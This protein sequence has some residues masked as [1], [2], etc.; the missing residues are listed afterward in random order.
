MDNNE[1]IKKIQLL[2]FNYNRHAFKIDNFIKINIFHHKEYE[3]MKNL[4]NVYDYKN[5][6]NKP[7]IYKNDI[8][9]C[10]LIFSPK[11]LILC[12][13]VPI[14]INEHCGYLH[15]RFDTSFVLYTNSHN[16]ANR[17]LNYWNN[18]YLDIE[19]NINK[20][21]CL[22]NFREFIYNKIN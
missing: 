9:L 13:E 19:K 8:F 6:K 4:I 5:N 20:E 10:R 11:S 7:I 15:Y 21:I 17:F 1:K 12:F 14:L 16:T 18:N 3:Q 22:E 2:C